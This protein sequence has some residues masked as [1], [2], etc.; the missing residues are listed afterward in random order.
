M[1]D[2]AVIIGVI[3]IIVSAISF[4]ALTQGKSRP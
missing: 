2:L 3:I 4:L 1:S